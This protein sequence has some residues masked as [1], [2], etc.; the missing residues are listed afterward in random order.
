MGVVGISS[1][2]A[3]GS[4]MIYIC[5]GYETCL[6]RHTMLELILEVLAGRG[7]CMTQRGYRS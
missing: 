4:V 7:I 6:I 1:E 3:L 2:R 5:L